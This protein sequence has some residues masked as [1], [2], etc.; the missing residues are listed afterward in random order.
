MEYIERLFK[1]LSSIQQDKLLHFFTGSVVLSLSLLFFNDLIS[2][3]IVGGAAI[4]KEVIY[5][6]VMGKGNRDM[7]DFIYTVLPCMLHL[8]NMYI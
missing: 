5:D 8:I 2:I 6:D 3:T 4:A 1:L 7:C